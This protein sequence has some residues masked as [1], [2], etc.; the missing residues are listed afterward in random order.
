MTRTSAHDTAAAISH[1]ARELKA[2]RIDNVYS[3]I[4]NQARSQS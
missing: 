4:A 1:L 3:T 2:P